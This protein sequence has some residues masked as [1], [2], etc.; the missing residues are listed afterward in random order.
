VNEH[1][2]RV[3]RVALFVALL[4]VGAVL[5]RQWRDVADLL[6]RADL[7]LL[8]LSWVLVFP[9]TLMAAY[10]WCLCLRALGV[11]IP[12]S[13]AVSIWFVGSAARY[14]P[15]GVW[16]Y[17]SRLALAHRA[18][19]PAAATASSMYFETLV[20]LASSLAAGVPALMAGRVESLTLSVTQALVGWTAICALL[21]PKILMLARRVPGR[22]GRWFSAFPL[23]DAKT[24][25]TLYLYYTL[26]WAG[27]GLAFCLLASAF[28]PIAWGDV[29]HVGA[30]FA[31]GYWL[32][33]VAFL[34][35]G[36]L[37]VREGAI[38]LLLLAVMPQD[39]SLAIALASRLWIM[40]AEVVILAAIALDRLW[41]AGARP[42]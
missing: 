40:G 19:V 6:A 23:P 8:A 25:F 24:V 37:G 33:F 21:H 30:T 12:V 35:P 1:L 22:I 9:L 15:G 5:W 29:V 3:Q 11:H 28:F 42:G 34:V 38:C 20:I 14:L 32:G 7:R 4:V 27:F 10:G 26:Y 17:A 41:R 18:G 13:Q 39:A 16:S 31:L 36:G 2:K